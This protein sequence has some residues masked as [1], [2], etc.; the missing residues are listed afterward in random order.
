MASPNPGPQQSFTCSF[1]NCSTYLPLR[2]KSALLRA[3]KARLAVSDPVHGT[4]CLTWKCSYREA[5]ARRRSNKYSTEEI[6]TSAS[7]YRPFSGGEIDGRLSALLFG[8]PGPPKHNLRK[9]V[10]AKLGWPLLLIDP[11]QFLSRG[12]ENIYSRAT[13]IFRDLQDFSAVVVLFDE[14]DALVRTRD[15]QKNRLDQSVSDDEHAAEVGHPPRPGV[16]GLS[17]C[18]KRSGGLRSGR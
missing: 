2:L 14:M 3:Y 5:A 16:V 18:D 4:T 1:G 15:G 8:P 13:E 7:K 6:L 10:A 11:S 9:P 12:I 17:V